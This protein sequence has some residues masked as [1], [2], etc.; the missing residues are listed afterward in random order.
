MHVTTATDGIVASQSGLLMSR[1]MTLDPRTQKCNEDGR[2]EKE[3]WVPRVM[4][5]ST[6]VDIPVVKHFCAPVGSK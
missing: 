4:D 6:V 1:R 3:G 5:Y 2:N